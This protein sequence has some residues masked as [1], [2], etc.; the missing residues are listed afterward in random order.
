LALPLKGF[1]GQLTCY[2]EGESRTGFAMLVSIRMVC[3]A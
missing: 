3:R 2:L 1:S